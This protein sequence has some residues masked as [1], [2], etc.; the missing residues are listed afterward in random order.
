[1][2]YDLPRRRRFAGKKRLSEEE[3]EQSL[4]S[5]FDDVREVEENDID[6]EAKREFMVRDYE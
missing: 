5:N 6:L 1:M 3:F 4:K 2:R